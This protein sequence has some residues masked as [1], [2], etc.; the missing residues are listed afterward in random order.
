MGLVRFPL[1]RAGAGPEVCGLLGRIAPAAIVFVSCDPLSLARDLAVLCRSG[2]TLE[3]LCLIDMFPQTFH[4][5]TIVWL[6]RT[7]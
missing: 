4:I 2:Y 6:R 3:R 5:E 1:P 7:A